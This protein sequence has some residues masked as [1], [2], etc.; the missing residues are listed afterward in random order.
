MSE[1]VIIR[2]SEYTNTY[3]NVHCDGSLSYSYDV[4]TS[5][6][7]CNEISLPGELELEKIN[8]IKNMSVKDRIELYK[9][10]KSIKKFKL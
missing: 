10:H 2:T 3:I 4:E 1:Y 8:S 9:S 7:P 5:T 6:N